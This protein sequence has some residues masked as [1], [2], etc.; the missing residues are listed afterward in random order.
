MAV[1]IFRK[2]QTTD[3]QLDLLQ[4]QVKD[5]LDS[6]TIP[7]N[8]EQMTALAGYSNSGIWGSV[9]YSFI[10]AEAR[11][12]RPLEPWLRQERATP[13][14]PSQPQKK[15]GDLRLVEPELVTVG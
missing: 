1:K 6:I 14:V 13:R 12:Y 9:S 2:L 3:K 11:V 7:R 15:T 5:T 10:G 8:G 4:D